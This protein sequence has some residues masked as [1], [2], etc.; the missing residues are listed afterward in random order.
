METPS[1][2]CG[3]DAEHRCGGDLRTEMT[4]FSPSR[5]MPVPEFRDAGHEII[6]WIAEYLDGVRELPVLPAIEPGDVAAQLAEE[7]PQQGEPIEQ[8]LRDFRE[9]IVPGNTH[10]N[11]PRFHAY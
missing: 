1:R 9:I 3:E 7:A 11:H 10:W 2:R 8:I 4:E 6:D 5:D